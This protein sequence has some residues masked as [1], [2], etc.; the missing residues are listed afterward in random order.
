VRLL[1][2]GDRVALDDVRQLLP[3]EEMSTVLAVTG[4]EVTCPVEIAPHSEAGHVEEGA[5]WW[6]MSDRTDARGRP[7]RPDHV[8]GVG[9]ASTT[10]AQLTV[11]RP[12]ASALDIGTGCGVQALHLSRHARHVTATDAVPRAMALAATGFALSGV[13]VELVEGDLAQ[14]VRDR[15]FDLVV[16]NPPFVVGPSARFRYR[17]AGGD[18]DDISCAAIR[19]AASVLTEG[20]VAQLLANWLHVLGEDWRDRVAAWV[21]DLGCDAWLVERDVQDPVDYVS[22]WLADAGE[23]DPRVAEQWLQW[24]RTNRIEAVG[25]GWVLLRRVGA[26]SARIAVEAATQPVEQPLGPHLAGWLDRVAWLRERGDDELLATRFTVAPGVR[27]DVA[28]APGGQ[29][30]EPLAQAL[31][32]DDGWRW[33]LPCDHATAAIVSGC[34]GATPLRTVVAVLTVTLGVPEPELAPAV[35]ATVRGLVDRG[36]LLP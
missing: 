8:L 10:L 25:F 36:L 19:A 30:W 22:T 28:S 21:A 18:G 2:I 4:D 15:A 29:G 24:F 34:D 31:R 14:P 16:C 26:G 5:D 13:D 9:G 23:D 32:L 1:L 6:V 33:T 7:Q 20:G 17:D 27:L 12:I 35:C 11:R 3:V